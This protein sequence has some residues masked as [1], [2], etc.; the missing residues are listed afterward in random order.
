M[1]S[2]FRFT[3]ARPAV[4]QSDA[5][6]SIELQGG[7]Q[8]FKDLELAFRQRD[9]RTEAKK[10]AKQFVA[11]AGYLASPAALPIPADFKKLDLLFSVLEAKGV[12]K[13]QDIT[14]AVE[15]AFPAQLR[16]ANANLDGVI[17][18]LKDT[19]V[20]IKLLPSEHSKPIEEFV[21][22]LRDLDIARRAMANENL[23]RTGAEFRRY[24]RRSLRLPDWLKMPSA[25]SMRDKQQEYEKKYK[26]QEQKQREAAEGKLNRFKR[27]NAAIKEL[28]ALSS[29]HVAV[30]AQVA[31]RGS[32]P[33]PTVRRGHVLAQAITENQEFAKLHLLQ[34]QLDVREIRAN[35]NADAKC[36]GKATI[37]DT[38]AA[39]FQ[40]PRLF[41]SGKGPFTPIAPK[42]TAFVLKPEAE[43][44]VSEQTM[45]FLKDKKLRLTDDPVDHI[46]ANLEAEVMNLARELD[47]AFGRPVER[48]LKRVNKTLISIA[49][50]TE[51]IWNQ[52]LLTEPAVIP[53]GTI[54]FAE[55][56]PN[57]HGTATASGV[58]DLLIVKQQ[59]VRYEAADVAHIENVL[60]NELKLR[61]HIL[62]RETEELT[63]RETELT[64][65]EERELESTNRFEM[66]QETNTTI[67]EDMA[68]KAGLTVSGKYGPT[69]DFSASAEGSVSRNKEESTRAAAKF[70]QDVTERSSHKVTERILERSSLKVVN[71]TIEKNNHTLNNVPG[72][73]HISGVYQWVS[74]VYQAQIFNYGM[75]T[76]YDFMVSEPAA[77]LIFAMNRS[78]ATAVEVTKPAPLTL[79]PD[80]INEFNYHRLVTDYYATD[81]Q[82]PPE[83]YKTKALDFKAGGGETD[84]DYNHS[85]LIT[86][87]DGYKAIYGTVGFAGN[88]WE[89]NAGIDV[90]LGNRNHRFQGGAGT[91]VWAVALSEET[92]TIPFAFDTWSYSQ[93]AVAV[94]VKCI[95]TDRAMMKW[96]LDTHAKVTQAYKARLAEYD[97]KIAALEMEAGVAIKGKNPAMNLDLM[98]EEIKKHCITIL[99]DQHFDLFDAISVGAYSVPQLN[100]VENLAEG[101]YVRFFEQA[102]E[103]E[104][105]TW[106]TYPYFWGRKSQWATKI[107]FEDT[108]PLFNQF[109]K[110]GYC[111]VSVPVRPGFESAID[112]F[113]IT[114]DTW[115]GGPLPTISESMYLPIA[116]E[117]AER[118]D[119]PGSEFPQGDPWLVRVP[120]T[121]VHLRPDDKLPRWKQDANGE[122]VEE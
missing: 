88:V 14:D 30:T 63:F 92:D 115:G 120:T 35:A 24:R 37:E 15:A 66:S 77:F 73:G 94:E 110:A 31:D 95:R 122:W 113:M 22:L 6:P 69:V 44:K 33:T 55:H 82:P 81:V 42:E 52:I 76:M 102:F 116:D 47:Q 100:L 78:H 13:Q 38:L 10:V 101:S 104:H 75:R 97:E 29:Q 112:H 7:S 121:L 36:V 32:L 11:S 56:V 72:T 90:V 111:R 23:E 87:D 58:S 109:L 48:S 53:W 17:G 51:S 39:R 50:P 16:S 34:A 2:L 59:L 89:D 71:E 108:D 70:S 83:I 65:S 114:G 107:S 119:R 64:T 40:D 19:I 98:N 103:W 118:L 93:V 20:A 117:I 4:R 45:A 84:K 25:L 85:G 9:A 96:R 67:R 62:R 43:R 8:L 5:L 49:T 105:M 54:S 91:S 80:Q 79:R 41:V 1:E 86:I 12:V 26:E 3:L 106:L 46:V 21:H 27:A 60:K 18:M 57:S 99:T 68:L 61:E 74:K 28:T